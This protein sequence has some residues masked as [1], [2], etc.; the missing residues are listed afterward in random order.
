MLLMQTKQFLV[1]RAVAGLAAGHTMAA[2]PTYFAEV[3]PPRSRGLITGAHAI[4]INI[5][6]CTAGWVGYVRT[7]SFVYSLFC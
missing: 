7:R 3:A 5:G 6:Y 2:M 1:A 4:F